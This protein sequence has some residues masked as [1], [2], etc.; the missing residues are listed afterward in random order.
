[1]DVSSGA[2]P[3]SVPVL[4]PALSRRSLSIVLS[5][6]LPAGPAAAGWGPDHV[7]ITTD[8]GIYGIESCTDGAHGALVAWVRDGVVRLHHLLASGDLDPGWPAG[9][10][11]IADSVTSSV[12]QP[13]IDVLSDAA[14]GA[15]VRWQTASGGRLLRITSRA[16]IAPGWP[17]EG[18]VSI[19][20]GA[21]ETLVEDGQGGVYAGWFG[22][23]DGPG[24]V[25]KVIRIGPDGA[26]PKGWMG[27]K[28]VRPQGDPPIHQWWPQIAPAGDGGVFVAW[29]TLDEGLLPHGHVHLARLSPTGKTAAGWPEGGY[30][31][32]EVDGSMVLNIF[33]PLIQLAPDGRG[34]AFMLSSSPFAGY[35]APTYFDLEVRL[36]RVTLDGTPAPGWPPGGLVSTTEYMH[37]RRKTHPRLFPDGDQ[38]A[39]VLTPF[40]YTENLTQLTIRRWTA[41]TQAWIGRTFGIQNLEGE[42]GGQGQLYLA[43][44]VPNGPASWAEPLANVNLMRCPCPYD[45]SLYLDYYEIYGP[46]GIF[47]AVEVTPT[48][49]GGAIFFWS[50]HYEHFGLFALRF[51]EAGQVVDVPVAQTPGS[52]H[53]WFVPGSGVRV[54]GAMPDAAA[55]EVELFD[56]TGRRVAHHG[57]GAGPSFEAVLPGS[58]RL[59][60]GL[61]FVRVRGADFSATARVTVLR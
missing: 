14:G 53:A 3:G 24:Y 41:A 57:I 22:L 55:G 11:F 56:V 4:T 10:M 51:N 47:G 27:P 6:I 52:C 59:G 35:Y 42:P 37:S 46:V 61:Y 23:G 18:I 13:L 12:T 28:T 5:L 33:D 54:S 44:V 9:G 32:E 58:E 26:L 25:V 1:M 16:T 36:R 34:G 21:F 60:T 7:T 43:N 48:G 40:Y 49:D 45:E 8:T 15:Y 31:Y 38:G 30:D 29:M 50:Q 19:P 2:N 17:A 39:F 20:S